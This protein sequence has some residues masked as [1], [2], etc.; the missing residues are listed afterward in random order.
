MHGLGNNGPWQLQRANPFRPQLS[1]CVRA[2]TRRPDSRPSGA[3][4]TDRPARAESAAT[5]FRPNF[6]LEMW[7]RG[8]RSRPRLSSSFH[9]GPLGKDTKPS[10]AHTL[11][12]LPLRSRAR[13]RPHPLAAVAVLLGT[14]N[15]PRI[16]AGMLSPTASLYGVATAVEGLASKCRRTKTSETG[17][18]PLVV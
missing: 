4:Q 16:E 18:S 7:R 1:V 12:F 15:R 17:R 5:H 10:F 3:T 13:R 11:A 9:L 8:Q 6:G 14:G 2:D